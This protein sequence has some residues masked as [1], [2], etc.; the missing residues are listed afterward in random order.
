MRANFRVRFLHEFQFILIMEG[1]GYQSF[2]RELVKFIIPS[3]K[4]T[5]DIY[6]EARAFFI[7]MFVLYGS[8]KKGYQSCKMCEVVADLHVC[9]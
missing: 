8:K 4:K 6:G 5:H 3:I 1:M 7:F 2:S 9:K